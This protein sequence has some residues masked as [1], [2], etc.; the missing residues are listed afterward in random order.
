MF[1][2]RSGECTFAVGS[3]KPTLRYV[4]SDMCECG[5]CLNAYRD[6]YALF[7]IDDVIFTRI[8]LHR[9]MHFKYFESYTEVILHNNCALSSIN[10]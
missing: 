2:I 9:L 6:E 5:C 3:N 10:V 8:L 1:I 7:G 4:S